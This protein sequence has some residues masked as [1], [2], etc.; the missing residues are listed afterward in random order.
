M[1]VSIKELEETI[2][3][4][5]PEAIINISDLANDQDHYALEIKDPSFQGLSLIKQHRMVKD[6]LSNLLHSRLHSI[7][8]KTKTL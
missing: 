8:I 6:A 3:I 1:A 4:A 2:R 5:F 7:T